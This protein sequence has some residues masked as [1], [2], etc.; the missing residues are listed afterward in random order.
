MGISQYLNARLVQFLDVKS[1]DEALSKLVD[2]LDREG[3]LLDKQTFYE[4]IQERE[5]IVSTGIGMGVAIPHAKLQG[6]PD[7]FIAIGIEQQMG[8]EWNALDNLPVRLI[9]VIGGPENQQT[10]Y[11]KILSQLTRAIKEEERRKKMLK[12]QSANEVIALFEGI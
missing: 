10:E 2:L 8:I 6:Y 9:F 3:K 7:F 1:R 11:L 5:K 4:A 12:A